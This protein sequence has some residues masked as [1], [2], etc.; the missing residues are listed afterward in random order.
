MNSF[1]SSVYF[2]NTDKCT[3]LPLNLFRIN[4]SSSVYVTKLDLHR[5]PIFATLGGHCISAD[6]IRIRPTTVGAKFAQNI[7]YTK[8]MLRSQN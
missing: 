4:D 7:F 2:R 1:T 8:L 6:F 3:Q 5:F